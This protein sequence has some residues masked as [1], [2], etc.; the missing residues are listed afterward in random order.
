MSGLLEDR[1][2]VISASAFHLWQHAALVEIYAENL[3]S[4]I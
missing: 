1:E 2:A 3:A 4:G